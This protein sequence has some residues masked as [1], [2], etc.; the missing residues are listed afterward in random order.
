MLIGAHYDTCGEMPGADDNAAAVAILLSVAA[1]LSSAP[2]ERPVIVAF[3]DAEEPPNFL[4]PEMGSTRFYEDQLKEEIHCA[5]VMDL[6][7]HDLQIP[8]LEDLLFVTGVESDPG[9]ESVFLASQPDTR[10]R[11]VPTLNAYVGDMSDHHVF[12]INRKPYLFLTCG[13]WRHYHAETDTPDRLNYSKME[14][15]ADYVL[16]LVEQV[17]A[18]K[19]HGPFEGYDTLGT[20]LDALSGY[21]LPG[22]RKLGLETRPTNE[23]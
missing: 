23:R 9:L 17:S 7:G 22:L 18:Q 11:V 16:A 13:R 21:V 8:G 6:V 5:I 19:L 15:I 10:L 1:T 20:E 3:F 14:A 2:G 12:R 4:S